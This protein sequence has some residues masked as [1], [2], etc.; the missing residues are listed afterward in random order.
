MSPKK[1][2]KSAL[3]KKKH[4]VCLHSS[5]KNEAIFIGK[6][7]IYNALHT[8]AWRSHY[9]DILFVTFNSIFFL[10]AFVN[11]PKSQCLTVISSSHNKL[12]VIFMVLNKLLALNRLEVTGPNRTATALFCLDNIRAYTGSFYSC[13][14]VMTVL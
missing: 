7:H 3:T 13:S 11:V 8:L 10:C 2:L 9:C 12:F 6:L 5:V 1:T 4:S 14:I